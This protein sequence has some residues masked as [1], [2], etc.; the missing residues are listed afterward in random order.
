LSI[1]NGWHPVNDFVERLLPVQGIEWFRTAEPKALVMLQE[2]YQEDDV[3]DEDYLDYQGSEHMEALRL[4]Y[5]P[6]CLLVGKGWDGGGGELVLLNPR[7]IFPDGEW[8]AIF[9][10]SWIPGNRRYRSFLEFVE[11]SVERMEMN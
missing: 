5:Y 7:I 6:D 3:S 1:S 4:R 11:E 2:C 9:F 8:E 10:A